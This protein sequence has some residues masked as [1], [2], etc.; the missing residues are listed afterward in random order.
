MLFAFNLFDRP[1]SGDIRERLRKEHMAYLGAVADQIAFAGP[2]TKD[3]SNEALG[4]LLVIDFPS[5]DAATE[6]IANEPFSRAG[7]YVARTIHPFSNRW[8]QKTGFPPAT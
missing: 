1:D 7:L 2:M 4:S 6:W 3:G 5:R 8:P